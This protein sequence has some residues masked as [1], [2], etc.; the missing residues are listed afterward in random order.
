M[1]EETHR[2]APEVANQGTRLLSLPA[3]PIMSWI[4]MACWLECGSLDLDSAYL[5]CRMN[6][7]ETVSS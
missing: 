4:V 2:L 6:V 3:A 1:M 7:V 5:G